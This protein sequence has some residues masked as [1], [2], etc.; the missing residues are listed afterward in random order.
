GTR[1]RDGRLAP[2]MPGVGFL[3]VQ[4]A[5]PVVPVYIDGA[6]RAFPPGARWIKPVPIRIFVGRPVTFTGRNYQAVGQEIINLIGQLS[7]RSQG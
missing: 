2:A 7:P 4:S 1:S 3:A 5:A 6:Y